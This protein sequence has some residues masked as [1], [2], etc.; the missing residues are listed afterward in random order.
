MLGCTQRNNNKKALWLISIFRL[1]FCWSLGTAG[2]CVQWHIRSRVSINTLDR[3]TIDTHQHLNWQLIDIQN[4]TQSTLDWHLIDIL[5][6]TWLAF[7]HQLV[8]SLLCVHWLICINQK[9]LVLSTEG[10]WEV[11]CVLTWKYLSVLTDTPW[12]PSVHMMPSRLPVCRLLSWT[13]AGNQVSCRGSTKI[14]W[15]ASLISPHWSP[16]PNPESYT[17]M[18]PEICKR[19]TT[20]QLY[21][22]TQLQKFPQFN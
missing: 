15:G 7:N 4:N 8:N 3:P 22:E 18:V 21:F 6:D 5:T 1:D 11:N 9:L 12:M 13:A 10:K 19:K 2:S 17:N 16:P 20:L 14:F